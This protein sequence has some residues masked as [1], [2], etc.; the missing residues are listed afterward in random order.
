MSAVFGIINKDGKPIEELDI[1]AIKEAISHRATDG[2]GVYTQANRIFGHCRLYVNPQQKFENQPYTSN[3]FTITADARLDNREELSKQLD[4]DRQYLSEIS[5]DRLILL[6]YRKWGNLCVNYM[7][8]EYAFAIWDQQNQQLFAATDHIGFRPFF[9][10]DSPDVF[11]FCSEIKGVVAA[12]HTPNYFEEESLIDYFYRKGTPNKTYN[13]EIF[14]LC[15]GNTLLLKD[16]KID[17]NKYW[18]LNSTGKYNFKKE[19]DWY[20]CSREILYRTV[21]K[22]INPELPTG[23]T[24]SGGLDS[25]SITCIVSELLMKKNKPLYAFSS[26]LPIDYKGIEKDERPYI[27]I[28]GKHCP[29]IIQTYVEAPNVGPL[30]DIEDAFDIEETF[31]NCFFYMDKAILQAASEKHIRSLFNGFGG[32][33]WISNKGNSVIYLLIK[34]GKY[35]LAYRLIRQFSEREN[36]SFMHNLR[37]RYL[38][39]TKT[40]K[41]FRSVTRKSTKEIDWQKKTFLQDNFVQ[42]YSDRINAIDKEQNV[43]ER[44]KHLIDTGRIGRMIAML[45]NRNGTYSMDS[46]TLLFDKELMEFLYDVPES[47]FIENGISRNLLRCSMQH[48]IP[49]SICLRN[50]KLP[51]SPGFP[52]RVLSDKHFYEKIAV[53]QEQYPWSRYINCESILNN[54][55]A[56]KPF[57]GFGRSDKI[58]DMRITHAGIVYS[59]VRELY[60]R[61]YIINN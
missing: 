13:K 12:K 54:F 38:S 16:G 49:Q 18:T 40:Y 34:Q 51:Y 42:K 14:A 29:N 46:F 30:T 7:E 6:A 56:V 44:G 50:D 23:V 17:I 37:L 52:I 53:D 35:K 3:D 25:T 43:S 1:T 9:Y 28:V 45:Y 24:L 20:D 36:S 2:G 19:E 60:Q 22:R 32:D 41:L 59:L 48:V 15:G 10:Y 26:V 61:G 11:I 31:P 33:Y 21:E 8:G 5:D 57:E 27:E 47:L 58:V 4:L 39:H 55:D